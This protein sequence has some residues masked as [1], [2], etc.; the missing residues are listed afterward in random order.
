MGDYTYG[1]ISDIH[2]HPEHIGDA[3]SYLRA[4]GVEKLILNGDLI[5]PQN[6]VQQSQADLVEVLEKVAKT[7]MRTYFMPGS[8]EPL[9]VYDPV[10]RYIENQYAN[11]IDLIDRPK[12]FLGDFSFVAIPGSKSLTGSGS[13]VISS[14]IPSGLYLQTAEGYK[15]ID[16]VEDV[17]NAM[18]SGKGKVRR[19]SNPR[20]W[21]PYMTNS[22]SIIGVCHEPPRFSNIK[23]GV[24][25]AEFGLVTK[26]I[27]IW[28]M[29]EGEDAKTTYVSTQDEAQIKQLFASGATQQGVLPKGFFFPKEKADEL[30]KENAQLPIAMKVE[31][32]GIESLRDF[33]REE[34]VKK[35]IF[36][37]FHESAHRAHD[38]DGNHVFEGSYADE[39]FYNSGSLD[40]GFCGIIHIKTGSD[41]MKMQYENVD[42]FHRKKSLI[43]IPGRTEPTEIVLPDEHSGKLVGL[44][45]KP[46][47]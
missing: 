37:H 9:E 44:D 33:Y 46:L 11:M 16:R 24:D 6:S 8:H 17:V 5:E 13:Y 41:G 4:K 12:V 25:M 39:L 31:N 43:A 26:D 40:E 14:E 36:G 20:S 35:G 10:A 3:L 42:L 30:L 2:E 1:V 29:G 34:G 45:G 15:P 38:W 47:F 27:T 7:N 22:D 32:R 19:I 21:A 23:T 28:E 18:S